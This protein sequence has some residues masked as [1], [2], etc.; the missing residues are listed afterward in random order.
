ML[1]VGQSLSWLSVCSSLQAAAAG[2]Q[3]T[4]SRDGLPTY[5]SLGDLPTYDVVEKPHQDLSV[6][7]EGS[8]GPYYSSVNK[9]SM[10][11]QFIHPPPFPVLPYPS[12]PRPSLS[13]LIPLTA[14]SFGSLM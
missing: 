2:A 7:G 8:F 14:P 1:W 5:S 12:P 11:V 4:H 9:V 13:V 3:L 6:A 10:L